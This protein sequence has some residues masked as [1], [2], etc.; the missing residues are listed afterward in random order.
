MVITTYGAD[1][2]KKRQP[3]GYA[4]GDCQKATEPYEA[5]E[6]KGQ[7]KKSPTPEAFEPEPQGVKVREAKI[8]G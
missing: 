6:I 2:T 3:V 7:M 1:G 5:R 4:G 8:G